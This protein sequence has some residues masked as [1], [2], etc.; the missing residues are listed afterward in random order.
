MGA[1]RSV[2]LLRGG[3][4]T[5]AY[6]RGPRRRARLRGAASLSYLPANL[7]HRSRRVQYRLKTKVSFPGMASQPC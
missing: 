2:C 5:C 3:C 7:N 4:A 1:V 6:E